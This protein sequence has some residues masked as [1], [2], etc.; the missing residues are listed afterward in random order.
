[1]TLEQ[2]IEMARE[3][4]EFVYDGIRYDFPIVMSMEE[5]AKFA[6]LVAAHE[7]ESCA[8]ICDV[9]YVE[10]GDMQVKTCHEAAALIRARNARRIRN[11]CC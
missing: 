1:M 7:R 10:P 4:G 6:Q 9:T 5:L 11:G 2:L 3:C 8:K